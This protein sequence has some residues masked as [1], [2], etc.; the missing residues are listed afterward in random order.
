MNKYNQR[1]HSQFVC[2]NEQECNYANAIVIKDRKIKKLEK[3]NES[4]KK[5]YK[6]L[7][8]DLNAAEDQNADLRGYNADLLHDIQIYQE[9][10]EE[11]GVD[12]TTWKK[13][14]RC[15]RSDE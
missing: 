11:S 1:S 4:L 9:A 13:M 15:C 8:R 3:Q 12:I 2:L 6:S 10:T 5:K 7:E 14:M